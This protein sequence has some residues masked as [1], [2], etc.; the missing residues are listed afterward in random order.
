MIPFDTEDFLKKMKSTMI[1]TFLSAMRAKSKEIALVHERKLSRLSI[2]KC[3]GSFTTQIIEKVALD[4][5][6]GRW[7]LVYMGG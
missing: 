2:A 7:P 3:L 5:I 1:F 4:L 6:H